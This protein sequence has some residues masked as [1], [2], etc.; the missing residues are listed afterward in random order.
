MKETTARIIIQE[1]RL[2]K[3]LAPLVKVGL[4]LMK[5]VITPLAKSVLIPLGLTATASATDATIKKKRLDM[6]ILISAN[7]QMKQT[8]KIGKS[9]KRIRS[10]DRRCY[11]CSESADEPK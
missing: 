5:N 3:F 7:E 8:M 10:I 6:T 1:G 9:L 11:A 2:L 4:P